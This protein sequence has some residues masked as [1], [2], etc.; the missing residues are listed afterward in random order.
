[1]PGEQDFSN[2][3]MP[4]QPFNSCVFPKLSEI[5]R[6]SIN[7]VTNPHQFEINGLNFLGTSGQNIK[8]MMLNSAR[9]DDQMV[10]ENEEATG[11]E[12][13]IC[14]SKLKETLEMR[15]L[16]PT[17]PDTLRVYPFKESDPFVIAQNNSNLDLESQLG[18]TQQVGQTAGGDA[19]SS[20]TPHV[21]FAGNMLEYRQELITKSKHAKD[22]FIKVICIPQFVKTH[23]IV[24]L[25]LQT[26][27]TQEVKF[28]ISAEL[29]QEHQI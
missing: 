10:D 4:Q 6:Q 23:S 25:D 1:M 14:L 24:L 29:F 11:A 26:M 21:Y 27:E 18:S 19:K 7:L 15:H 12:G 5:P 13:D 16:C 8:D 22:G 17:A 2:S 28:D 9:P 20:S 3:F